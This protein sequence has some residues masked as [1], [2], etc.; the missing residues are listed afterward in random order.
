MST[1]LYIAIILFSLLSSFVSA[2]NE[3]GLLPI[4]NYTSKDYKALPQN[5]AAAQDARG[6][7]YF[8]NNEGLLEFKN[9]YWK[10]YHVTNASNILSLSIDSRG[11]IFV[12]ATDEFGYFA[13]DKN[14]KG[15]L[16]YYSLAHLVPQSK[17]PFHNI[18]SVVNNGTHTYFASQNQVFFWD[19]KKLIIIDSPNRI[20]SLYHFQNKVYAA[21]DSLGLVTIENGKFIQINGSSALIDEKTNRI[22]LRS[23]STFENNKMLLLLGSD[24]LKIATIEKGELKLTNFKIGFYKSFAAFKANKIIQL[25][26]GLFAMSSE[27]GGLLIFDKNGSLKKIITKNTGL[28]TDLIYNLFYDSQENLW[29]ALDAGL[30]RIKICSAISSFPEETSG[31]NNTIECI[32]KYA[33]KTMIGTSS[34]LYSLDK[35]IESMDVLSQTQVDF[36]KFNLSKFTK[37]TQ[38]SFQ[39]KIWDLL[40]LQLGKHPQLLVATDDS[41]VELLP[42]GKTKRIIQAYSYCLVQSIK[43]PNRIFIGLAPGLS[44]LYYLNG[45]WVDEG[46]VEGVDFDVRNIAQDPQGNLWLGAV[47]QVGMLETPLFEK[48]KIKNPK[49]NVFDK[50][51][52][53]TEN[54]AFYT[55]WWERN[56][57]VAS[58]GG[59][60]YFDTKTK[61]F[62]AFKTFG[63][64][65]SNPSIAIHRI[66]ADKEGNIWAVR[67]SPD[68]EYLIIEKLV[69]NKTGNFDA[70]KIL[71]Q[72]REIVH[73]FF[74]DE[75]GITW[76]GG[77]NGLY[78]Y[79]NFA[80]EPKNLPFQIYINLVADSLFCG[81]FY[82]V[83]DSI[84]ATQTSNF[85]PV[86]EYKNNTF[87][88]SFSAIPYQFE[89]A[90]KYSWYLKGYDTK[91]KWTPWSEKNED[92]FTNLDEGD[93]TF[94][95][96]ARDIYGNESNSVSY[97]FTI[98]PPWYR[99]IWAYLGYL[100]FFAAF[101][102]GAINVSTRGLRKIIK[103]ATAEI[104]AQKD[105]L[106]EKNKNI[107]D[108]IRY[109]KRI[110]EAVIP[111][112]SQLTK[113]FPHNFV[114]F[115]PR[116]IVSGDFY[117]MMEKGGKSILAA[118]DCT[119]HGVPGA[120]MS[121]MGISFLN[122]I[123]NKKEVQTA[124]EA[125]NQLRNSVITSL[126]QEGSETEAK[127]GMDIS[128]CVF[129]LH[130]KKLQ[131]AGAYNP[132]YFIRDGVIDTIKADRMPI[133]IHERDKDDFTNNELEIQKGDMYYIM[134]DGYIDQFGGI[135][136]KKFMAKQLKELLLKIHELPMAEQSKILEQEFIKWRGEIEQIDDVLIIGIRIT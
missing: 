106:E 47:G 81:L 80:A 132:L 117:W 108:S 43:D 73:C 111:S 14:G 68:K 131:F 85:V 133:G 99:T 129:D 17:K 86:V 122:E 38:S 29:L 64:N 70:T 25:K 6:V 82:I 67:F 40:P 72:N 92:R 18:W 90:L 51:H 31:F 87:S 100:I 27:S 114:L 101:V 136:G 3:R 20:R 42:N 22:R 35:N 95:V 123:A 113:V 24:S 119:G 120:F 105:Q 91:D 77:T 33:G 112:D 52:N 93:Y 5:W 21:I 89:H 41:I 7:I 39:K 78:R 71:V 19:R 134:S 4:K 66:S 13:P 118:A 44:S 46:R 15:M 74:Q 63:S 96:K 98:K 8:G 84:S 75:N 37:L 110:Q 56:L 49:V 55:M 61:S 83:N 26:N 109:A 16:D 59:I 45:K 50:R 124:A 11:Y 10:L 30:S 116:D 130:H 23:L 125:L 121:I 32:K 135:D 54:D 126:N 12:G 69:K 94:M 127:D 36:S 57:L 1:K 128:L 28:K 60:F 58:G 88:F 9:E 48:N 79:D 115:R 103:A 34:G 76:F 102:L 107:L 65:Y 2:Q 104:Q 97:S 53:L 62:Q